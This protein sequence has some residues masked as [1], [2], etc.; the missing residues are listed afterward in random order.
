M[1][2]RTPVWGDG[3]HEKDGKT[4]AMTD[5]QKRRRIRKQQQAY[6]KANYKAY[7]FKLHK[8]IDADLIAWLD[9]LDN[10]VGMMKRVFREEMKKGKT[11]GSKEVSK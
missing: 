11:Q 7:P 1:K 6:I 9:S 2:T 10:R 4:V 8:E 3:I 5:E